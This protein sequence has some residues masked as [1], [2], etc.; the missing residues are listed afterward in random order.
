MVNLNEKIIKKV[1]AFEA[2]R[3]GLQ[4]FMTILFLLV[5]LFLIVA[6]W[7]VIWEEVV[8]ERSLDML[9]IFQEDIEVI[10][11]YFWEAMQVIYESIPKFNL[12]IL[13]TALFTVL[14]LVV[15]MVK[16]F[17]KLKNRIRTIINYRNK[18]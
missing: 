15:L 17:A 3:T 4:I 6:A 13:L 8:A 11:M 12:L 14:L 7:Q 1:Y 18:T 2:K 16:N 5:T 10:R 9:D